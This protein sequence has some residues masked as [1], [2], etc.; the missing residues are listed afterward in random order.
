MS[1]EKKQIEEIY[2]VLT[3]DCDTSCVECKFD[4]LDLCVPHHKAEALYNA[5]YRKQSDGW[6]EWFEDWLPSTTEHPRECNEC[7]WRCHECKTALAD[8]VG[9]YWDDPEEVP[10][11]KF[12]PECGAK[13]R[14]EEK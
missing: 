13:M 12:C 9:G 14:G 1:N 5:G 4:R 6:W 10:N 11:L 7:G 3:R 8:V 2:E